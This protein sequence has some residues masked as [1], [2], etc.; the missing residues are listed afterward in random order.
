ME[1]LDLKDGKLA[2]KD[3]SILAELD[4]NSQDKEVSDAYRLLGEFKGKVISVNKEIHGVYDKLGA[5]QVENIGGEVLLCNIINICI[6]V[7]LNIL[8]D[9][10]ILMKKE[11]Q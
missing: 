8:E 4:A 9:K 11:E 6:L 3:G 7:F 5:A 2:F 1:Q 10:V